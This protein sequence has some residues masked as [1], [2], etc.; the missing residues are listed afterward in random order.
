MDDMY[1]KSA[2]RRFVA[3]LLAALL[4]LG[5]WGCNQH[6]E[7]PEQTDQTEDPTQDKP[8]LP[9]HEGPLTKE[10][11]E[12]VCQQY[13]DELMQASN[14][15]SIKLDEAVSAPSETEE[16]KQIRENKMDQAMGLVEKM[17][18]LYTRFIDLEPPEVYAEAHELISSGAVSS[19]EVLRLTA[20]IAEAAKDESNLEKALALQEELE[21]H[22][23]QAQNFSKGLR[24]VLGDQVGVGE[25][26]N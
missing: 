25:D 8:A 19:G 23:A 11:Y 16:Q 5:L 1:R 20:A 13:Y 17:P 9:D 4:L 10:E 14:E 6:P 22:T 21:S 12:A 3:G 26:A 18:P 2:G 15:A 24:M 7:Q